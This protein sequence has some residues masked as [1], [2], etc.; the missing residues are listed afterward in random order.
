MSDPQKELEEMKQKIEESKD[1]INKYQAKLDVALDQLQNLVGTV[2]EVE[3][4][5]KIE[6][7]EEERTKLKKE[8][9]VNL[10]KLREEFPWE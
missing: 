7:L 8:V 3:V 9:E 4:Q 6:E 10:K 5:K 1:L 2:D